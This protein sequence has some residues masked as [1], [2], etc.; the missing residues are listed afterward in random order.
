MVDKIFNFEF[1]A[2]GQARFYTL[3]DDWVC[4]QIT[5]VREENEN[6]LFFFDFNSVSQRNRQKQAGQQGQQQP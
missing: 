4:W 3:F 1:C 2:L 5:L 6:A